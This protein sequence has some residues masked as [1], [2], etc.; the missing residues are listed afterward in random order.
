MN[1]R[2][3]PFAALLSLSALAQGQWTEQ[4]AKQLEQTKVAQ[5][6]A[7]FQS[8]YSPE[9]A[10]ANAKRYQREVKAQ[11]RAALNNLL[12]QTNHTHPTVMILA[13][14]GMPKASLQAL[15]RQAE[16]YQVPIVI[17]GL[18]QNSFEKTVE[19]VQS[20]ILTKNQAPILSGVEINPTVFKRFAITRVPAFIVVKEGACE[21][22]A[23]CPSSDFDVVMGNISLPN[24]LE[25]LKHGEHKDQ[26]KTIKGNSP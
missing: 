24:A 5:G 12:P 9:Q 3:L 15:L 16:R 19:R 11:E 21:S 8:D 4:E 17:R 1:W 22:K 6:A 23:P 20:L 25:L 2:I 10:F 18:Y 7:F 13:S 26:L 14:L